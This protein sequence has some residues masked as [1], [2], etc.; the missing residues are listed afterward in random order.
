MTRRIWAAALLVGLAGCLDEQ[1]D[2]RGSTLRNKP[3]ELP[4]VPPAS[5]A[6]AARVDQLG[7]LLVGQSPFL[8][9]EPIFQTYGRKE[10]EVFHPGLGL[11]IV[12]EGLVERC[13][14]DDELAAV[15]SLE[16]AKMSAERRTSDRL[17]GT[18]PIAPLPDAPVVSAG[19]I[20]PDQ[21]QLGTQAL[22]DKKLGHAGR[23][24]PPPAE[25]AHAAAADILKSAGFDPKALDRVAPLVREAGGNHAVAD[26]MGGRPVQ[27][28]WSN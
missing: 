18:D 16:L 13:K 8:G 6:N 15:L 22:F 24:K 12:T 17:R 19:G 3:V 23:P 11:V 5:V 21:N 7:R 20:S 2:R 25:D 9:V 10:P 26:G 1:L 28:V 14:T 27:P 4:D